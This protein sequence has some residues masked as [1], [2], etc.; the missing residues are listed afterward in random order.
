MLGECEGMPFVVSHA[1]WRHLSSVFDRGSLLYT[2]CH[3]QGSVWLLFGCLLL[4]GCE[5]SSWNNP[6]PRGEG[7]RVYYDSFGE[8]PKHLDPAVSYS[9]DE[10]R[11]I[12]QIYEPPLQY[13]LLL[14]PY[15]LVPLTVR[16]VPVPVLLDAAGRE[17][18]PGV[19][20]R[21]VA[22]S[23]Y[24]LRLREG[25]RYQP[26]PALARSSSGYLYH[27]LS[28]ADLR[29]KNRLSDFPVQGSR[30]LVAADYV[31]QAKRLAS[32][33]VP[34][35]IYGVMRQHIVGLEDLRTRLVLALEEGEAVDLRSLALEGV[36]ATGRYS[37][38][39]RLRG[40]Y[41]AFVYWLAMPFFAPMPWEADRFYSQPGMRERNI[42]LDWYPIG[43][44]PYMLSENNPNLRMVL[45]RNPH[46]RLE[47]Y[48][49]RGAPGDREAGMLVDAGQ[50]L[51]L[52]DRAVFSREPEN[53]PA[54]TK[55]LQGYYDVSGIASDNFDQAVQFSD[56]K[57]ELTEELRAQGIRLGTAVQNT[58]IYLGFNMKDPVLGDAVDNDRARKLRQAISI[59]LDQEE[60]ISIDG[61]RYGRPDGDARIQDNGAELG[62]DSGGN[63]REAQ[64]VMVVGR[65]DPGR[66]RQFQRWG[67]RH[68]DVHGVI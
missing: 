47:T 42:V 66:S 17:L 16:E 33:A 1:F 29:G 68:A 18:P 30:E 15:R 12:G 64:S 35:P 21:E 24:R 52:I 50:A 7:E 44:G 60:Y 11:L 20:A 49:A 5:V 43:T 34:S 67:R 53:I 58:I 32:P 22:F 36:R 27:A 56:G 48:P 23:V 40:Y 51:P 63:D 28:E 65:G 57:P 9:S 25:L 10:Y 61:D 55:F 6:Y 46:Y 3:A 45:E 39:I 4:A 31:Y 37:Y 59:A 2:G 13:H 26:H 14:R 54:W 41:P 38:E 19:D 62:A 8:R